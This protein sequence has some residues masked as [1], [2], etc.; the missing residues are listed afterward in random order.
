MKL[1]SMAFTLI[2]LVLI[3]QGS[4][5]GLVLFVFNALDLHPIY[6]TN[7]M[8]KYA[9]DTYLI[10]PSSNSHLIPEELAHVDNW[11]SGH[12]LKLNVVMSALF[13]RHICIIYYCY[14][15]AIVLLLW[16]ACIC[17]LVGC[18]CPIVQSVFQHADE[19]TC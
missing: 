13:C 17:V 16:Y 14:V 4:G 3:L 12:N 9:D 1:N 7:L 2:D 18:C 15:L 6:P 5:V 8:L 11:A 19:R 10:I